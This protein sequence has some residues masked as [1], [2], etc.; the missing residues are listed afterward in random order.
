MA[1]LKSI[2]MGE[3]PPPEQTSFHY[4]GTHLVLSFSS[5]LCGVAI[6][7]SYMWEI[8]TM[9]AF[10]VYSPCLFLCAHDDFN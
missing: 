7:L 1:H 6:C 4:G 5:A 9:F 10:V 3:K 2:F 8:Q